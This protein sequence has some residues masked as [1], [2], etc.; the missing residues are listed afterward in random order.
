MFRTTLDLERYT[1]WKARDQRKAG[2]VRKPTRFLQELLDIYSQT[3]IG[4]RYM[5]SVIGTAHT[6]TLVKTD[7]ANKR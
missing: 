2:K 1:E 4:Y 7:R 6:H 5:M 3:E